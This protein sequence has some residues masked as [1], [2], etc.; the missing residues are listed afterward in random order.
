MR[1]GH[2]RS[3]IGLSRPA[4]LIAREPGVKD[5]Q[6]E[7]PANPAGDCRLAMSSHDP[8]ACLGESSHDSEGSERNCGSQASCGRARTTSDHRPREKHGTTT[9]GEREPGVTECVEN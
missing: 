6:P 8:A 9:G 5:L 3:M 1:G 7:H 2:V 4:Q